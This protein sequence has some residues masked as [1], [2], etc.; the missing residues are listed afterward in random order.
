TSTFQPGAAWLWT[1]VLLGALYAVASFGLTTLFMKKFKEPSLIAAS[2]AAIQLGLVAI[3]G[4]AATFVAAGLRRAGRALETKLGASNP[5][6][7]IVAALGW[8]VVLGIPLGAALLH[9]VPALGDV[10]P[11]RLV[12]AAVVYLVGCGLGARFLV[13]RGGL[14]PRAPVKRRRTK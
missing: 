8:L 1:L 3:L 11:W 2:L 4:I 7:R 14:L 9:F 5:F 12:F 13:R 10:M 6:G